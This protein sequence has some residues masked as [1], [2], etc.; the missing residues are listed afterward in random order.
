M[1]MI[2]YMGNA[3]MTE[4]T[5]PEKAHQLVYAEIRSLPEAAQIPL[6]G[7]NV[8]EDPTQDASR[9]VRFEH[10]ENF[11][12]FLP[13]FAIR[14]LYNQALFL[15]SRLFGLLRSVVLLSVIPYFLLALLVLHWASRYVDS[16]FA[17]LSSALLMLTPPIVQIGQTPISDALSTLIAVFALYLL[18]E[19]KREVAG[20]TLLLASIFA[21]TDNVVLAAPVFVALWFAKRLSFWQMAALGAFA[22]SCVVFINRMAGDPGITMLYYR[23]F[24]GT[25]TAPVGMVVHFSVREYLRAAR[26]NLGVMSH[27]W[28]IPFLLLAVIGFF[29][30][31]V[32]APLA[33][34]ALAYVILHFL[35]VPNWVER[36]FVIAYIPMALSAVCADR[37]ATS[38]APR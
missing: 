4:R 28:L 10:F 8:S 20:L 11:G 5:P 2:G 33:G 6:L 35:I 1:D 12:E 34:V 31:S 14:P 26:T 38:L 19:S 37:P 16:K 3:L 22:A 32:L 29:R 23:N 7:R 9:K 17:A 24:V 13:F 36:W 25:P 21:R 27:G 18:F 15:S 30:R